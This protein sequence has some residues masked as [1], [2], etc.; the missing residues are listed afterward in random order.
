[1]H[2]RVFGAKLVLAPL[3]RVGS[4]VIAQGF[5]YGK[6]NKGSRGVGLTFPV[7]SYGRGAME[8]PAFAYLWCSSPHEELEGTWLPRE[9]KSGMLVVDWK[10]RSSRQRWLTRAACD[11]TANTDSFDA[12]STL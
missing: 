10:C 5:K 6:V 9:R 8:H 7:E 3:E 4:N 2:L 1:M 12:D 11:G